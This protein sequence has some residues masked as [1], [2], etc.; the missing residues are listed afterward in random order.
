MASDKLEKGSGELKKDSGKLK[1]DGG[2]NGWARDEAEI[3]S[4]EATEET[5]PRT[6]SQ[7]LVT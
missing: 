2:G 5:T 1:K 3:Y 6:R 7:L 4:S